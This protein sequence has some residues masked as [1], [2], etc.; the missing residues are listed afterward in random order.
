MCWS[1]ER[2]DRDAAVCVPNCPHGEVYIR[3]TGPAGFTMGRGR[4]HAKDKPHTVV[5]TRPFCMDETEVTAGAYSR[6]IEAGACKE[7][8]KWDPWASYPRFPNHPVNL[9]SQTKAAAY[10]AWNGQQ[11]PTEAQWEWAATGGDGREWPW[12]NDEPTCENGYLDFTPFGAPKSTPGGDVGCH[13]GGPSPVKAHP[14]GAKPWPTGSLYDLAGNVWEWTRD[15]ALPYPS[16]TQTNPAI[17][18]VPG[19]PDWTLFAIRGGGWNRSATGCTTWFRGEATRSYQ[20]P[21]LGFRCVRES[22]SPEHE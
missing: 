4:L 11:L 5:L 15:F 20:V 9:V 22:R 1:I 7:P 3:A 16:E 10:C 14:K 17:S 6:C 13:G 19:K 12:G 21:G 2:C 8:Y 18:Q